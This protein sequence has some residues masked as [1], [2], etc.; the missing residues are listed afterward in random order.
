MIFQDYPHNIEKF[1]DK[2][3]MIGPYMGDS[4]NG[5]FYTAMDVV[6]RDMSVVIDQREDYHDLVRRCYHKWG[7]LMRNPANSFGQEQWDNYLGVA[8]AC[9]V[10]EE[11]KIPREILWYAITH[12]FF[13]D[14]DGKF[15]NKDWLGRFPQVWVLMFAAAFPL[16]KYLAF[17]LAYLISLTFKPKV[18]DTSANN[19]QFIYNYGMCV[20]F[21]ALSPLKRWM[22]KFPKGFSYSNSVG[23]YFAPDH[24]FVEITKYFKL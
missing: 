12:A 18:E 9:L 19:L 10:L 6:F 7:C 15:E 23:V 16:F 20:A 5:L 3:G 17:P 4:G 21:G 14:T 22:S 13:M 2:Y 8:V 11:T 1:T 24:P